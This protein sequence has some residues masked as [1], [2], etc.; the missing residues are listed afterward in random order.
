MVLPIAG[1]P[2]QGGDDC[3]Q[4]GG[5]QVREPHHY[6][7]RLGTKLLFSIFNGQPGI[8]F[9]LSLDSTGFNYIMCI[10]NII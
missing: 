1:H 7:Y 9:S 2:R 6:F 3:H 8:M 5:G 4:Q 10:H